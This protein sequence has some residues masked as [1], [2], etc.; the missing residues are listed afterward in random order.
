MHVMKVTFPR[1]AFALCCRGCLFAH[2][3]V[4]ALIFNNL[5]L[6]PVEGAAHSGGYLKLPCQFMRTKGCSLPRLFGYF[7]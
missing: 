7:R 4:N 5:R 1:N 6:M 3:R 2:I